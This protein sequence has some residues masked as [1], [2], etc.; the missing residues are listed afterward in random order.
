M[1]VAVQV[2]ECVL[3]P[4]RQGVALLLQPWLYVATSVVSGGHQRDQ[5]AV[6]ASPSR[7]AIGLRLSPVAPN[8]A[9]ADTAVPAFRIR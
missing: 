8:S 4:D 5:C 6:G 1:D 3:S 9:A 7:L 2:G